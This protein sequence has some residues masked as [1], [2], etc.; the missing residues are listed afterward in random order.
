MYILK[1]VLFTDSKIIYQSYLN[2]KMS[3]FIV[4]QHCITKS[5]GLHKTIIQIK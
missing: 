3:L 5:G 2:N 1:F 4:L